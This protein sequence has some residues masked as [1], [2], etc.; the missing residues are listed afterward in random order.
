MAASVRQD[1]DQEISEWG[2]AFQ[3]AARVGSYNITARNQIV[4]ILRAGRSWAMDED[5]LYC[6]RFAWP[7]P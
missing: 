4:E 7:G 6:R 2:S 1:E 3:G 5:L